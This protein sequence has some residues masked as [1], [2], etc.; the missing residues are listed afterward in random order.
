MPV[1][2]YT[3]RQYSITLTISSLSPKGYGRAHADGRDFHIWNALPGETVRA[4][5]FR[6]KRGVHIGEASEILEPSEHRIEPVDEAFISTAPWQIMSAEYEDRIKLELLQESAAELGTQFSGITGDGKRYG[7]RNKM[8][9]GLF[10]DN[11][12]YSLSFFKR[13]RKGKVTVTGSSLAS[14]AIN[15]TAAELLQRINDAGLPPRTLKTMI[16]RSN[17]EGSTIAGIFAKQSVAINTAELSAGIAGT[18]VYL[19]DPRSPASVVTDH[20]STAGALRLTENILGTN[21]EY[22]LHSFFQVN[23]GVFELALQKMQP[24]LSGGAVTDFYS[25]TGAISI[26]VNDSI[27]EAVLADISEESIEY[28]S[29]NI[30]AAGLTAY[31]AVCSP[32]EKITELITP[33]RTLILDPPRA[34]LHQDVINKILRDGPG[35]VMYLSCNPD[36]QIRDVTQLQER[37]R[38][39]SAELL[40]FFPGTPH[41]ESLI[42]LEQR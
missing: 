35:L 41:T 42:V 6:R 5:I 33:D 22:G 23:T 39:I 34:G 40:N 1:L 25:G 3:M 9:F 24:F 15:S 7:Y 36:T 37:Y 11:G 12:R 31:S 27:S 17:R 18:A 10:E 29:R 28:A 2:Y 8:E 32:A 38:I 16:V 14:D 21:L 30:S 4:E 19:S 20:I 26:P 13:G